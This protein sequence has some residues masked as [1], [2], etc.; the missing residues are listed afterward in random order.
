MATQS[1]TWRCGRTADDVS[2][3]GAW[4]PC[5]RGWAE[6]S[7]TFRWVASRFGPDSEAECEEIVV[8]VHRRRGVHRRLRARRHGHGRRAPAD[9][10]PRD[11]TSTGARTANGSWFI[12]MATS[13]RST[14]APARSSDGLERNAYAHRFQAAPSRSDEVVVVLQPE[15]LVVIVDCA[16]AGHFTRTVDPTVRRLRLAARQASPRASSKSC[17]WSRAASAIARWPRRSSSRPR[18]PRTTCTE[19]STNSASGPHADHRAGQRA[20]GR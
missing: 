8:D 17:A 15:H 9:D 13:P 7:R 4:G 1:P 14:R 16:H 3:F 10:H 6:L 19:S 11:A 5:K 2:L 18:Q 12:G 20:T